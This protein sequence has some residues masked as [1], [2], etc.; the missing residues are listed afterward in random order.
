MTGGAKMPEVEKPVHATVGAA[1]GDK[2][3]DDAQKGIDERR[4]EWAGIVESFAK[5]EQIENA[6]RK[7]YGI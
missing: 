4:K 3:R 1:I 5:F 2:I 6:L 7:E